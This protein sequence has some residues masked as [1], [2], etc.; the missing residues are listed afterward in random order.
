MERHVSTC[1]Y[2]FTYED[3]ERI[4]GDRL[5]EFSRW[6]RGQ[7]IT[8]CDGRQFNHATKKYEPDGCGPHGMVVYRS[9]LERFLAGL[10]V[11]D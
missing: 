8:K 6:M 4:L 11:I 1:M 7:T 9:D 3:Q 5:P 10:P 2:G